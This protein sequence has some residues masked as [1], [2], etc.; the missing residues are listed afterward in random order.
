VEQSCAT[1]D[2]LDTDRKTARILAAKPAYRKNAN[3]V[4]DTVYECDSL[5]QLQ[6]SRQY[7]SKYF[8]NSA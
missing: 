8:A 7:D 1:G 5:E 2:V 3:K 4:L 6:I